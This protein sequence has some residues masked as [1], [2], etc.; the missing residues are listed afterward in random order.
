[1]V[2]DPICVVLHYDNRFLPHAACVMVSVVQHSAR[3]FRFYLPNFNFTAENLQLLRQWNLERSEICIVPLQPIESLERYNMAD[4]Y[5]NNVGLYVLAIPQLLP[6]V[7]RV[8]YLDCDVIAVGDLGELWDTDLQDRWMGVVYE[9]PFSPKTDSD[10]QKSQLHFPPE[11]HYFNNGVLL[12]DLEV[13]RRE[14]YTE[15][16]LRFLMDN[17][18]LSFP[19]QDSMNVVVDN[20]HLLALDPG[21]NL[22]A[23]T[24][25]AKKVAQNTRVRCFHSIGSKPWHWYEWFV[26]R[27]PTFY[28]KCCREYYRWAHQTPWWNTVKNSVTPRLF[29]T[30]SAYRLLGDRTIA[31]LKKCKRFFTHR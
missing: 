11:K 18:H 5:Y 16:C 8:I 25:L 3:H 15:N 19:E 10:R 9:D 28:G 14:H 24:R 29:F 4:N 23:T 7:P 31:A 6:D 1:M 20:A 13:L 21:W 12:M 30:A 2:A 26:N 17:P 22:L 27:C